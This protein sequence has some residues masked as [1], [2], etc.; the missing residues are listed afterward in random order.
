MMFKFKI[1]NFKTLYILFTILAL[2][3]FFFSTTKVN[4]KAFEIN[5]IEISKP[6]KNDFNKNEV[7]DK[8]FKK[9]FFKL[10]YSLIKSTDLEKINKIKLNEIKGMVNTFSIQEEKFVDQ[11][12]YVNLGVSFD[13]KKIFNYLEKKNIFPSQIR[14]ETFLFIPIL[15]DENI[16]DLTIFSENKIYENWNSNN[17]E[18]HLINYLLPSEDLEDFNIIKNNYNNIE[19]YNFEDIIKKY[20]IKNSIIALIF[21]NDAEIRVLSKISTKDKKIIKNKTFSTIDLKDE[22]KLKKLINNLKETYE[23]TWKEYNQ[24]NT[25]I[26]LAIMIKMKNDNSDNLSKFENN[27][28]ELDL[29]NNYSIK[30]FN[31]EYIYYEIIF[32]GTPK[33]FIKIMNEKKYKFNTEKKVWI[34]NE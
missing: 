25:S 1:H 3:I 20:F 8:G 29:V 9:A 4:A 7:L 18:F 19:K 33:N 22:K 34:L 15:I 31:K 27:L 5:N 10:I 28:N 30:K 32:N 24:I 6:F 11:T 26:K 2:N 12:Y 14:K 17:K 13:K 16:N 23:D 21:K